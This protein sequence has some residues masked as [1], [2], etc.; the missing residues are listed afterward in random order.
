MERNGVVPV[1]AIIILV[2]LGVGVLVGV[3]AFLLDLQV[4]VR[5]LITPQQVSMEAISVTC[6]GSTVTM[7]IV[8]TGQEDLTGDNATA[9]L[10]ESDT[11]LA[12]E[13]VWVEEQRFKN[14]TETGGIGNVSINFTGCFPG[15]MTTNTFYRAEIDFPIGYTLRSTC[16][17]Q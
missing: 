4:G 13:A 11:L 3:G 8:N 7:D 5:D 1:L 14:F 17:A 9:Y 6:S 15:C 2:V 10:Y 16:Y 12:T